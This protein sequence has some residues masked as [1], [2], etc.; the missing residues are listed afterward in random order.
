MPPL[1]TVYLESTTKPTKTRISSLIDFDI[2]EVPSKH[3][4]DGSDT[5]PTLLKSASG[6]VYVID[7]QTEYLQSLTVLASVLDM[8][9]R[10]PSSS[11]S[12]AT[13]AGQPG[14]VPIDVLVHKADGV[15]ELFRIETLRDISQRVGDELAEH[16][17]ELNV[18]FALTS[19]YDRSV[20]EACSKVVQKLVPDATTQVVDNLMTAVC[21]SSGI[22]K[23]FL[24]DLKSKLF[25]ATD[26]SVLDLVTYEVCIDFIDVSMDLDALY[27][28]KN[29]NSV[30]ADSGDDN[31]TTDDANDRPPLRS[32]SR[33]HNGIAL[34]LNQMMKGMAFLAFIRGESPQKLT[35]VDYNAEIVRQGLQRIWQ[36]SEWG[37]GAS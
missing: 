11:A 17:L 19:L 24:V 35:L 20:Y 15:S 8:V 10:I 7:S 31:L 26:S 12:T 1:D 30:K 37:P 28:P 9:R 25:W 2:I 23:A 34:Y 3:L 4:T 5:L 36:D 21:A 13:I 22:E 32:V 33:M 29:N 6:V 27:L 16:D 14:L 18:S